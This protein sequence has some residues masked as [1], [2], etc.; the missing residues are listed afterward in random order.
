MSP[1]VYPKVLEDD[2]DLTEITSSVL[3]AYKEGLL[4]QKEITKFAKI[5]TDLEG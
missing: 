1:G 3:N 4:D 2:V 5:L